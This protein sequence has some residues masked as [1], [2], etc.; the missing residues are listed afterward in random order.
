[1]T[2]VDT[3]VLI[4]ASNRS[5]PRHPASLRYIEE[6]RRGRSPWFLSWPV[7]FEYLRVV[8]HAA[9]FDTPLSQAEGLAFIDACTSA[10]SCFLLVASDRHRAVLDTVVEQDGPVAGN[11]WHDAHSVTLMREHGVVEIATYD[12]D[13]CRF[14]G[15][16]VVEPSPL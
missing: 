6:L 10:S 16:R 11:L 14:D 7:V 4:Y 5:S 1:M 9:V 15:I 3:N 8:T 2:F 13:F 12:R